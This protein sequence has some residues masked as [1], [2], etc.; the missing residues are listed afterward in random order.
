ML[1]DLD[2]YYPQDCTLRLVLDNHSAHLSKETQAYLATRPNRFKYVLT[3]THGSWLNLAET[4]V[5]T[6]DLSAEMLKDA[7]A[8]YVILGHS[9]RRQYHGESDS[10][11]AAKTLAAWRAGLKAIV[12]V[13]ES[14]AQRD[15][16][17]ATHICKSQLDASLPDNATP[18]NT[19]IAYEPVWAI[20]TGRTP[21][22]AE[23][24]AMHAHIRGSLVAR[25]GAGAKDMLILYGG[26]VN[27]GNACDLFKEQLALHPVQLGVPV[28][29]AGLRGERE[30]AVHR[31][32]RVGGLADRLIR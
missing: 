18:D 31:L 20:G 12:C 6:G 30:R 1:R 4:L 15:C 14:Q 32:Q 27:P 13:G 24:A 21:T 11:V 3:P 8:S 16:G 26:S 19:V 25:L 22:S 9:E 10:D 2:A 17:D 28:G 7:G 23:I 5:F 29:L